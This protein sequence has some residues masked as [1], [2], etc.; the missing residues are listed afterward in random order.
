M[1]SCVSPAFSAI[2]AADDS[3]IRLIEQLPTGAGA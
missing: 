1:M 2:L 3:G